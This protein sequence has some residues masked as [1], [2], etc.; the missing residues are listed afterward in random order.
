MFAAMS[1]DKDGDSNGQTMGKYIGSKAEVIEA[2]T[3]QVFPK[4]VVTP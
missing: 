2:L 3:S 4:A 1:D